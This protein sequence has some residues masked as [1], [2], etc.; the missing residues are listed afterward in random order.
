MDPDVLSWERWQKVLSVQQLELIKLQ[1][2]DSVA[3]M[4]STYS[5]WA[6]V[7]KGRI[8]HW[9]VFSS[10]IGTASKVEPNSIKSVKQMFFVRFRDVKGD[11]QRARVA[12]PPLRSASL[13][14]ASLE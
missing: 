14:P 2:V 6:C 3:R 11:L 4:D 13:T 9:F 7:E 1:R 12:R 10:L 8:C 5:I